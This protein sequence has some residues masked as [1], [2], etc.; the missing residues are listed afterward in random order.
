MREQVFSHEV[1]SSSEEEP[2]RMVR[3]EPRFHAN[4]ND[5]RVE[6]PEFEGKLDPEEFL[7]WL[8]TVERVFEYKDVP[9]D[10]KVKLVS[11]SLGKYESMCGGLTC[12]QNSQ[13]KGNQKL[14]HGIKQNPNSRLVFYHQLMS[15]IAI[16]NF[17][18][19]PNILRVL[20]NMHESLRSCLLRVTFKS[21]KNKP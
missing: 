14:M 15:K 17:I 6:V 2:I 7:D 16:L 12:V 21:K 3:G 9:D 4:T 18:T 19:L 20:K 5:F 11:L 1:D 10:K 13:E 8:H